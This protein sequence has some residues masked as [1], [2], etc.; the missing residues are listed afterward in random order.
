MSN[1]EQ[2]HSFEKT[3][4]DLARLQNMKQLKIGSFSL[5]ITQK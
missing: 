5:Q 3:K 4:K 1:L 2:K